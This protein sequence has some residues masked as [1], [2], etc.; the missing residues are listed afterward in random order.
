MLCLSSAYAAS[1]GVSRL[2]Y[3]GYTDFDVWPEEIAQGFYDNDYAVYNS[4]SFIQ[5][6]ES[7]LENGAQV[8]GL[9]TKFYFRYQ[10]QEF[11]VGHAGH[12]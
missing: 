9:V 12:T 1:V 5:Q 7:W 3:I 11:I 10:D 8:M 6:Q 4:R 2:Q